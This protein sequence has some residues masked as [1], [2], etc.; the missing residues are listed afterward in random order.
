MSARVLTLTPFI[1]KE[2]LIQALK[3]LNVNFKLEGEDIVTERIDYYGAQIFKKQKN[4][5]SFL[6]DS[7]AN[8]KDYPYRNINFK[9]FKTV[10]EF[11]KAIEKEYLEAERRHK[12]ELRRLEEELKR[13]QEEEEKRR[14]EMLRQEQI[15]Q[16]VAEQE[17]K[18]RESKRLEEEIRKKEAELKAI[19]EEK[20]ALVAEQKQKILEKA[21]AQGYSVRE[22][23]KGNNIQLVLIKNT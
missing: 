7:S 9:N 3:I 15:N 19:E 10:Q 13:K 18:D 6:H 16:I 20:K 1:N 5:Y 17:A 21:K 14:K 4:G 11:L 2:Y 12:E 23:Q 22:K 8:W